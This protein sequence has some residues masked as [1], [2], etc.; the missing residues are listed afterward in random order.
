MTLRQLT[1]LSFRNYERETMTFEENTNVIVGKNGEG[2]TN[3]LEGIFFLS[4]AKSFRSRFDKEL[5]GFDKQHAE[6]HAKV[7]LE[8]REQ[9]IIIR[10]GRGKKKEL[11][12]NG[13]KQKTSSDLA[14]KIKVVLF[15]PDDLQLIRGGAA[16]RRRMVDTCLSQLR[17]KYAVW[18]SEFQ[19]LYEHKTRILKDHR[20]KPDL[21]QTLDDFNLR[22][23]QVGAE[24]IFYRAAFLK[25]LAPIAK[26]VHQDFS[27]GLETLSLEYQT[28]GEVEDI[29]A[30]PAVIFEQLMQ[31]QERLRE[32]EIAAGMCLA[33][34]QKDDVEVSINGITARAFASQ[35]QTRTAALS[36]KLAERE[37]M[38]EDTGEYPLLLLD[39]VLSE[40]D[41]NRQDFVLNRIG[42]GQVFISCCE[43]KEITART[44]G[45]VVEIKQGQVV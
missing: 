20:E 7:F 41:Q 32:R 43:D 29:Q 11:L 26:T 9:E 27:G 14:G 4:G 42:N 15:S 16:E 21:L 17:P 18:L 5:I 30:K 38:F 31:Q 1:L 33:G 25:K 37:L 19:K 34:V 3:L 12:L 6:I 45:T 2:K 28:V 35:G 24:L 8:Q 39:D 40:L 44:G 23:A 22:L 36:L 13:V 10:L